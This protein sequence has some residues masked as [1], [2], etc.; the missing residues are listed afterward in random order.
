M[1]SKFVQSSV[2]LESAESEFFGYID[3][4]IA[5]IVTYVHSTGTRCGI[6]ASY[7]CTVSC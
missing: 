7:W 6:F 5:I 3:E 4:C 2:L 1:I